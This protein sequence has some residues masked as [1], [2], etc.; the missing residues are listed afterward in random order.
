ML[1]AAKRVSKKREAPADAAATSPKRNKRQTENDSTPFE[2]ETALRLPG[3]S[4]TDDELRGTVLVTNRAPLV[5]TF[6]VCILKYT[7]P[8]QPISSRLSLAQAVVSA[9]S[10]T[11]AVSLGIE[12]GMSAEAEGWGEGHPVVQVLGREIRVLKRW[13]Y[14]PRE[15]EPAAS[16]GSAQSTATGGSMED[17]LGKNVVGDAHRTPPLWGVDLETLRKSHHG[18]SDAKSKTSKPLPIFTPDSARSYLLRS[19]SRSKE[20]SKEMQSPSKRK[21]AALIEQEKEECVG[22]LLHA[23]DSVC[24]SWVP[25]L[26]KEELDKRAWAWYIRV[27]PDVQ[28]GVSGWGEKGQ[29]R[30]SDILALRRET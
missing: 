10:R 24:Q 14:N 29:V 16:S 17:I 30:L 7:M 12:S 20:E 11:K 3:S 13:D 6:A 28:S 19:F 1:N 9:N 5:L 2:I 18:A 15:G 23:I 8:E 4:A 21:S 25:T 26:N 27:R 22:H